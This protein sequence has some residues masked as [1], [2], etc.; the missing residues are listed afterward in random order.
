MPAHVAHPKMYPATPGSAAERAT[1]QFECGDR[2]VQIDNR[3]IDNYGQIESQ[4]AQKVDRPITVVIERSVLDAAGKPTEHVQRITTKVGPQR[5]WELGLVMKLGP[6][7]AVQRDSPAA[8]AGLK[9]GDWIA[10]PGGDP[11][12]LSDRL[13]RRAGQAGEITLFRDWMGLPL[14]AVVPVQLRQPSEISIPGPSGAIDLPALGCACLVLNQIES[15]VPDSPAAKA[16]IQADDVLTTAT[17]VPPDKAV[18]DFLQIQP[19]RGLRRTGRQGAQ[20][21]S[22]DVLAPGRIAGDESQAQVRASP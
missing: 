19:A 11:L 17:L 9:A 3:R 15:V 4:L 21:A 1:P 20:L 2:I 8:G 13:A 7:T 10:D 22:R 5:M 6:I 12:T 18:L 16:G 14:P